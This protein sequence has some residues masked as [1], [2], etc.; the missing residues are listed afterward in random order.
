MTLKE[1]IDKL[2]ELIKSFDGEE[3][4]ATND[5]TKGYVAGMSTGLYRARVIFE[6]YVLPRKES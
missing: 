5:Y 1:Y 6:E 3:Q 2:N 4:Q